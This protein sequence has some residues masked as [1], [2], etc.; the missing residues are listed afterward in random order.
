MIFSEN[1]EKKYIKIKSFIKICNFFYIIRIEMRS[2]NLN[3]I[4][5]L[6][7]LSH[8]RLHYKNNLIKKGNTLSSYFN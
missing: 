2:I 1:L 5:W 8:I 7:S 3:L 6:T 4:L